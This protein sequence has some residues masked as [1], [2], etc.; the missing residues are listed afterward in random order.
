VVSHDYKEHHFALIACLRRHLPKL[1]YLYS[2]DDVRDTET[3][4]CFYDDTHEHDFI[5]VR[6]TYGCGK[7]YHEYIN[8]QH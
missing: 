6:A 1:M 5:A 8:A 3:V 7:T 2:A 4:Q